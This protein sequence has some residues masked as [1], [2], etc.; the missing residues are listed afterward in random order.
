MADLIKVSIQG[1]LPGG[2]V[3]SVNPVFQ[4]VGDDAV[5]YD[6][7][8]TIALA[9][10]AIT[11]PTGLRSMWNSNTLIAGCRVEARS[12]TGV[13]DALAEATISS[14]VYGSGSGNHPGQVAVVSSL[15][16][17]FPG[18]TGRGRLYWPANGMLVSSSTLRPS[19]SDVTAALNGVK[20]YL[21]GINTAVNTTVPTLGLV[22]WSRKTYGCHAVNKILMGDVL[23]VQRRRRDALKESYSTVSY[24]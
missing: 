7:C 19:T 16:T 11:Q 12:S 24:P 18:P 20:T 6:Q 4:T 1:Q 8:N 13:L 2:E 5:T 22:V 17:P 15:R 3:W 23:D 10:N 21:S 9:I 14:P